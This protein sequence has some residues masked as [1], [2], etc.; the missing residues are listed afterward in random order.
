MKII[1]VV[2]TIFSLIVCYQLDAM[3]FDEKDLLVYQ[4]SITDAIERRDNSAL[5]SIMKKLKGKK[6]LVQKIAQANSIHLNLNDDTMRYNYPFVYTC[7]LYCCESEGFD[8]LNGIKKLLKFFVLHG[9]DIDFPCKSH[10]NMTGLTRL[11]YERKFSAMKF[12]LLLGA[13]KHKEVLRNSTPLRIAER[14]MK[15]HGL[16]L[17]KKVYNF[18]QHDPTRF[19]WYVTEGQKEEHKDI[20]SYLYSLYEKRKYELSEIAALK[21]YKKKLLQTSMVKCLTK[22]RLC[23]I[24]FKLNN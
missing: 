17:H 18:L 11:V 24:S 20:R 3:Q 13:N 21:R 1:V 8:T 9:C 7:A 16:D 23:N 12:F 14:R 15:I 6:D 19:E 4:K 10:K 22:K 5:E 2:L